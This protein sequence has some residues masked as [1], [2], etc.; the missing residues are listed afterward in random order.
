MA[1]QG[2][3]KKGD[4]PEGAKPLLRNK[5]AW[6]DFELTDFFEAGL[7][8]RG[9]EVKS[10]REARGSIAEAYVQ[11][12][13]GEIWLVGASVNEWAWAHQFNH[14]LTRERKLL[15][16]SE[17]IRKIGIRVEQKGFTIVPLAIYLNDK[18]RIKI[19][20]ALGKGKK[21]FEKR[22]SKKQADDKVEMDR[23]MKNRYE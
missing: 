20:I 16:H 13:K 21:E 19:Q 17:E 10:L 12:K 23:A 9:S 18:G 3:K 2:T 22:Q 4:L 11:L 7:E 14:A 15:L 6:H 1:K 5:R 8:L